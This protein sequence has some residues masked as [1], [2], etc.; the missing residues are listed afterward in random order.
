MSDKSVLTDIVLATT[1]PA[2]PR[3]LKSAL[4][5]YLVNLHTG[6][7]IATGA[8]IRSLRKT[9]QRENDRGALILLD[10]SMDNL[11]VSHIQ[12]LAQGSKKR[13]AIPIQDL[14]ANPAAR[15]YYAQLDLQV[16]LERY[17]LRSKYVASESQETPVSEALTFSQY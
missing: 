16:I 4:E 9:L 7:E 1:S 14:K 3:A 6:D 12:Q 10:T 2:V 17:T 5:P 8:S 11:Y 13:T 15:D